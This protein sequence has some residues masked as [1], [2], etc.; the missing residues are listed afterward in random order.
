MAPLERSLA[1]SQSINLTWLGGCGMSITTHT[2]RLQVRLTPRRYRHQKTKLCLLL[3]TDVELALGSAL[4]VRQASSNTA[5]IDVAPVHEAINVQSVANLQS[6]ANVVTTPTHSQ[7]V[8]PSDSST[9]DLEPNGVGDESQAIPSPRIATDA[10]LTLPLQTLQTPELGVVPVQDTASPLQDT[11]SPPQ[12]IVPPQS[13]VY[14][15]NPSVSYPAL[16]PPGVSASSNSPGHCS[17]SS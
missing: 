1:S 11:T 15:E 8:G 4:V 10:A 13:F 2:S 9:T 16:H 5:S 14:A 17:N 6:I 7:H 12:D 3:C